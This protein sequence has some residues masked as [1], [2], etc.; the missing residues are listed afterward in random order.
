MSIRLVGAGVAAMLAM[1]APAFAR[2][3]NC[4]EDSGRLQK[5]LSRLDADKTITV[6]GNCVGNVTIAADDVS[7]VADD[8]GASITGQVEVK[9]QRVSLTGIDITGPE[10]NDGTTIRAGLFARDGASVTYANGTIANHTASGILSSRGSSVIVTASKITGNG[11][12]NIPNNADGVQAV[13]TGSVLLGAINA[14]NGPVADAADEV[15]GNTGRGILASRGGSIR[16]LDGNVHD[17]GLQAALAVNSGSIAINGGNFSVP[18]PAVGVASDT[19]LATLGGTIDTQNAGGPES[20]TITGSN[21]GILSSDT[22]MVRVRQAIVITTGNRNLDPAV[23]AFRGG[24]AHIGGAT[25]IKNT[26]TAG[27]GWA[28]ELADSGTMRIDDTSGGTISAPNQIS[29]PVGIFDLSS[30]RIADANVGSSITGLVTVSV[31]SLL[32]LQRA[33]IIGDLSLVGPSTLNAGPGP[34][35]FTGTLRCFSATVNPPS[36][37][38]L[39]GVP[40]IFNPP[41]VGCPGSP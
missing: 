23:G 17:N 41:S 11:T 2:S 33:N 13:D 22:G 40:A 36:T 27:A 9:G 37:P 10:P 30:V 34:I 21:G 26:N 5:V 6:K 29:G 35:A 32:S 25:T 14:N 15:A 12:A 4:T 18:T 16:I 8:G 39:I 3:V 19:V 28:I 7:L 1:A 31:N 20:V 24:S 38:A